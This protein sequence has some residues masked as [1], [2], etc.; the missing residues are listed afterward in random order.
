MKH[1]YRIVEM[2]DGTFKVQTKGQYSFIFWYDNCG[3]SGHL[4]QADA[5]IYIAKDKVWW[6]RKTPKMIKVIEVIE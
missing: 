4:S 5:Y 3:G 6:N 2:S 1:K